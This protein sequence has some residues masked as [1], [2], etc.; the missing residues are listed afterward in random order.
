MPF[1]VRKELGYSDRD[2]YAIAVLW[3]PK[4]PWQPWAP[5]KQWNSK[6]VLT[7]GASCDT[8]YASG[9]RPT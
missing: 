9:Q 4:K 7:H 8:S 1:I 6:L 2:Q 3:Q 5:Q